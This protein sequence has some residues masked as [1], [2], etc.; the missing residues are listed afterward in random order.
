MKIICPEH[1]GLIYVDASVYNEKNIVISKVVDCPV[2]DD[3]V[4]IKGVFDID[5][6]GLAKPAN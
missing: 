1:N 5:Q 6:E 3:L 2:C 4:L